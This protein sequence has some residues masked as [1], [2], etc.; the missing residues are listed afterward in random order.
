MILLFV[1]PMIPYPRY[2]SEAAYSAAFFSGIILPVFCILFF[3]ELY[4]GYTGSVGQ[5]YYINIF[6]ST[7]LITVPARVASS[8]P[9]K[10]KR[11]L[12]TFAARKYTLMV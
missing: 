4:P 2:S 1:F 6:A 10:V 5:M 8:A 7:T 12:V 9:A 11:V 3:S